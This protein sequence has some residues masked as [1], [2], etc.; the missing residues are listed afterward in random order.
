MTQST[1]A[2]RTVDVT[3]IYR[4]Y[5]RPGYRFLDMFGLLRSSG[6][7]QEHPALQRVNLE[8]ARGEK[9]A[10][11]GRN[12]AGKS[13][14]LKVIT[15][16]IEPTSGSVEV[17][18]SVHALL[19][20]G[21]GFHPD[22]TGRQ[23]VVAYLAQLGI[24]GAAARDRCSSIIEFAE[25]EEYIDQPVKTYS[26]GMAVRLMFAASTVIVPDILVLDEILGVGD[27]YFAQ[28]SFS[29]IQ[30]LCEGAGTTV[31]L[32]THDLYSAMHV[33]SRFV[34]L[35][36]GCV[37]MDGPSK[38]VLHAYEASIREQEEQRLRLKRLAGVRQT[39][40]PDV[41][42]MFAQIQVADR[43]PPRGTTAIEQL[44][45]ISHDVERA[46]ISTAEPSGRG[47][48]LELGTGDGNWSDVT[49][50]E[51]RRCRVFL[52][53][54][55]IFHRLPFLVRDAGAVRA[56]E[57]GDGAIE[58]VA[59]TDTPT[60]LEVVVASS[61]GRSTFSAVLEPFRDQT[62]QVVRA[63]LLGG[64]AAS[65]IDTGTG[66]RYGSR[67]F[68][69]CNVLFTNGAGV[70]TRV[71]DPGE[72][73]RIVLEYQLNDPSFDQRPTIVVA[74][75]K[76]GVTRSHRFWTNRIRF[77]ASERRRGKV[78]VIANP[79]L[80]GAGTY[81]VTTSVFAEGHFESISRHR[82]F[83][84]NPN[85][86]DMHARAYEIVVRTS[87]AHPLLNDVVF[88]HPSQWYRDGRPAGETPL[89]GAEY[90]SATHDAD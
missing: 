50:V 20:I 10:I 51:G 27:A 45:I 76:D 63:P 19:Q 80:L 14:L 1:L 79:L 12:G 67:A 52:P 22:F 13:T 21:S 61:D 64:T 39:E 33:C 72:A 62:W 88:Q 84:A 82:F 23:N 30:E 15:R 41:P 42:P 29:R 77:A 44:R 46:A 37:V 25:L 8:V 58:V 28:K 60:P 47:L 4:L 70:D 75:Q 59:W 3:K 9:V 74:F 54:G 32:V 66:K 48:S 56:I 90:V 49:Q 78:E 6:A 36:R 86:F 73:M 83:T 35:D 87:P 65:D 57:A 68:E 16:V 40:Q 5:A 53:H 11:V 55:S 89:L 24:T 31:L 18:G 7:Y 17:D 81:L 2:V 38:A 34:W 43:Q 26:T 71:F 69:I 85:V